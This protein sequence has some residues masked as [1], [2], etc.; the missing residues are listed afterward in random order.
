MM[1]QYEGVRSGLPPNTLLLFRLGDFYE[2]FKGDAEQGAEILGITLT[3]RHGMPMAGIPYHA[4]DN[5]VGKLLRAGKKV[6]IC[7]QVETPRPGTIVKRALTR[8]LTPGTIL[9]DSQVEAHR[10]HYLLAINHYKGRLDSAWMDLSTGEF[11]IASAHKADDLLP[12]FASL[13]PREIIVPEIARN[14]WEENSEDGQW[15]AQFDRIANGRPISTLP[16]YHFSPTSGAREVVSALNVLNLQGFGVP[17][18]HPALGSAGALVYYATENLCQRPGNLR[19]IRI[20]ATDRALLID[21]VTLRNLEVFRSAQNLRH[22]SLL[23]AMDAT[24]T[25]AGARLLEKYLAEPPLD[26]AELEHRQQLVGEF[27]EVPGVASE[28]HDSL[29]KTRD[30]PRI[31]GRLQNRIRNPREL[32]GIRDT[33]AQIPSIIRC[34][35]QFD[36]PGIGGL[37]N[38]IWDFSNL[39]D[40]FESA[41]VEELPPKL[42]EGGFI[43][44]GFDEEL[45][46]YR[47]FARGHKAWISELERSEQ[48]RTGIRNLRIRYNNVFGYFIE[49]TKSNLKLVPENYIRKQTMTNAERFYTDALKIREK[50]ILH[51]EEKS[52][53]LEEERFR[54]LVAAVLT[55]ADPL[56]ETAQ[57]MAEIDVYLG[58]A[59][60][61]REWG[62]CRPTVDDSNEISIEQGRHPVIEQ[63]L[64]QEPYGLADT[65]TFVPNDTD[66][67]SSDAQIHLVTGPNMAGKSTYIRQVALIVL[68]AQVGSWVPAKSC[69][70]GLVDRIFSRVGATDEL[71]RGNS[72]FMVEMNETANILNNATN[73]SLIILDEIG[74]GTST[75]DGLSIA[76]AVVEQLHGAAD[77]GPRTLFATHYHELTQLE[78]LLDRVFNYCVA[79]KE[80][81]DEIIFVRQVVKGASDRSYGIQ[82][83]RLA[84]IPR[85]VIDRAK[86]ILERLEA[87]D[88]S[89]NLIRRRIKKLQTSGEEITEV[90][91]MELF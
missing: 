14:R 19:R 31:V 56:L 18:D 37:R 68:M 35:A 76:W 85:T 45:D 82:V 2:L 61:A 34:L 23:D 11:Q 15:A 25:A 69:R 7:D 91:Q 80:W 33:V 44:E 62:Y 54:D 66:L 26:L 6:A 38:R 17:A 32:G 59:K 55:Q 13:D 12:V 29:K 89:H 49:V 46:R 71:A 90:D 4:A 3:Q 10:N 28:L 83:A 81:N 22:G 40:L 70:L 27:L 24:V 64:R 78:Q 57:S 60:R 47:E 36:L 41:L 79:V 20:Y 51:A 63:M 48:E 87:D 65:R 50:E 5:Y 86:V 72:T 73:R 9:E 58:W 42:Q 43:R 16:D 52:I 88:S 39:R 30:L 75:Y 8:I 21:P 67:R 77:Q 1:R 84:G 74:R 53:A